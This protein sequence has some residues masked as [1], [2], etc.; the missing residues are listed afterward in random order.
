MNLQIKIEG[1][2]SSPAQ[3]FLRPVQIWVSRWLLKSDFPIQTVR[4][5]R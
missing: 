1:T 3:A 2:T 4:I 5:Q